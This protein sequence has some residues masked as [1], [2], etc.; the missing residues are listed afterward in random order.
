[1]KR[2]TLSIWA[3]AR[4]LS[5]LSVWLFLA[6]AVHAQ[7]GPGYALRFNN[8]SSY[9]AV[10]QAVGLNSFPFTVMAWVQTTA[11]SGQ[12]GLVNKYVAGSQNGWNLF[13]KDGLRDFPRTKPRHPDL[14]VHLLIGVADPFGDNILGDFDFELPL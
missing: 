2:C 6:A 9:V 4:R 14:I 5:A 12:Q 1:M 11:A 13:L 10:P 3:G 8:T 7:P